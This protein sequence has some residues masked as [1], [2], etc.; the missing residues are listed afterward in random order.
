MELCCSFMSRGSNEISI[1]ILPE[2]R[3]ERLS[4]SPQHSYVPIVSILIL[5]EERM[6]PTDAIPPSVWTFSFQS[7][8]SPKRGWS[9]SLSLSV[10]GYPLFQSSSSP[11]RGWSNGAA[12]DF[13]AL[14]EF[15]SSSS[16]KRG[17]S[18]HALLADNAE[19]I[20]FQSSSSPKRG[21]SGA[22]GQQLPA[23]FPV[24]IL[25][26]PE[27]RM[28]RSGDGSGALHGR[29]S[30]LIL[31]EER[32]EPRPTPPSSTPSRRFNPHPPRR[33]DGAF[34]DTAAR[35]HRPCFNPHPP[36]REDG[37]GARC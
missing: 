28:E 19:E 5:P 15:Q 16:P 3:M 1:L 18:L 34:S 22:G 31:P 17:W 6:E 20:W 24:S 10:N 2:E 29:V 30:I 26:L 12:C 8:S 21:W 14:D 37:A 13:Y 27:E 23:G 25:I 32:M 35:C 33:E 36:R 7:S 4:E 11:K 9:L